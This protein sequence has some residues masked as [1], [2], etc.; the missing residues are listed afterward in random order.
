MS[1]LK[2][3][4]KPP[5]MLQLEIEDVSDY[6]DLLGGGSG[7]GSPGQLSP[8][9]RTAFEAVLP[10]WARVR[11]SEGRMRAEPLPP[12]LLAPLIAAADFVCENLATGAESSFLSID[13]LD[14]IAWY[15]DELAMAATGA[16]QAETAVETEDT[17]NHAEEEELS[18][19]AAAWCS[20]F[21]SP[22]QFAAPAVYGLA[23]LASA[24][25]ACST[26]R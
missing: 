4:I 21:A 16:E 11:S 22:S 5:P 9:A 18:A 26:D 25:L 23:G 8:A 1:A 24:V 17:A 7:R 20:M 15:Q 19:M 13:C 10:F 6:D 14:I 12:E 3:Q 2:L